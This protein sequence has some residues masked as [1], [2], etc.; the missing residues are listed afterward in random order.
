M[1][2]RSFF[3]IVMSL[4]LISEGETERLKKSSE[5]SNCKQARSQFSFCILSIAT[6]PATPPR[7]ASS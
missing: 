3:A 4:E 5:V 1:D 6:A 2:S 7:A